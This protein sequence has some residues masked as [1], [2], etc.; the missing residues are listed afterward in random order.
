MTY[1]RNIFLISLIGLITGL[2]ISF[3][4]S[5]PYNAIVVLSTLVLSGYAAIFYYLRK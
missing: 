5:Y 2:L 1:K 3:P 4:F